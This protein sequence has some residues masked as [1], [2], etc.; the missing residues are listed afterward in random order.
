MGPAPLPVQI[1]EEYGQHSSVTAI[2]GSMDI[3]FGIVTN[4]NGF[5][6]THSSMR[7]GTLHVSPQGGPCPR[8]CL[9]RPWLATG[10][11]W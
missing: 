9:Q 11:G 1:A 10:L 6:F 5:A 7:A 4:L 8:T 2:L 3:F